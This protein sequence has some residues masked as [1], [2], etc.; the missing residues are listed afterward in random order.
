MQKFLFSATLTQSPEKIA[1]LELYNP[2]LF[3]TQGRQEEEGDDDTSEHVG[4]NVMAVLECQKT[5]LE[6]LY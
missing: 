5:Y 4:G 1:P 6:N 3:T 2:V